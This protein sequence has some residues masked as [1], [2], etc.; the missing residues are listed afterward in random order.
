MGSMASGAKHV[1]VSAAHK[2]IVNRGGPGSPPRGGKYLWRWWNGDHWRYKYADKPANFHGH[3][4][5]AQ[6][7]MARGYDIQMRSGHLTDE[8]G[9]PVHSDVTPGAYEP[10]HTLPHSI[11]LHPDLAKHMLNEDKSLKSISEGIK[12][13]EDAEDEH[14]VEALKDIL[15]NRKRYA[16]RHHEDHFD[17]PADAKRAA[18]IHKEAQE[19]LKNQDMDKVQELRKEFDK[20]AHVRL[21]DQHKDTPFANDMYAASMKLHEMSDPAS[22]YWVEDAFDGK[23]GKMLF[24]HTDDPNKLNARHF[25]DHEIEEFNKIAQEYKKLDIDDLQRFI[26]EYE[27]L[28]DTKTVALLRKELEE[29]K[30][31]PYTFGS[32]G[33]FATFSQNLVQLSPNHKPVNR[34]F[35]SGLN[36]EAHYYI[37]DNGNKQLVKHGPITLASQKEEDSYN[38]AVQK[39]KEAG[40]DPEKRRQALAALTEKATPRVWSYLKQQGDITDKERELKQA[41]AKEP[42]KLSKPSYSMDLN[43]YA[44]YHTAHHDDR[45]SE[46]LNL[47]NIDPNFLPR[48]KAT[49]HHDD[50]GKPIAAIIHKPW[51]KE[52]KAGVDY[53]ETPEGKIEE[54]PRTVIRKYKVESLDRNPQ[55]SREVAPPHKKFD[56][57]AELQQ[58]HSSRDF[59]SPYEAEKAIG[60]LKYQRMGEEVNKTGTPDSQNGYKWFHPFKHLSEIDYHVEPK[61]KLAAHGRQYE[62]HYHP[63][64]DPNKPGRPAKSIGARKPENLRLAKMDENGRL[65][66]KNG[67]VQTYAAHPDHESIVYKLDTGKIPYTYHP[68]RNVPENERFD[69]EGNPKKDIPGWDWLKQKPVHQLVP[70]LT[71]AD[72]HELYEHPAVKDAAQVGAYYLNK[73]FPLKYQ[74]KETKK[75][76]ALADV[77]ELLPA[78]L[79]ITYAP[80]ESGTITRG[81]T[82]TLGNL[83]Q[84]MTH[85]FAH[86]ERASGFLYEFVDFEDKRGKPAMKQFWQLAKDDPATFLSILASA[87]FDQNRPDKDGKQREFGD[88]ARENYVESMVPDKVNKAAFT[89]FQNKYYELLQRHD[90]LKETDPSSSK[91]A[92]VNK[93]LNRI[94]SKVPKDDTKAIAEIN[95]A[96]LYHLAVKSRDYSKQDLEENPVIEIAP[97]LYKNERKQTKVHFHDDAKLEKIKDPERKK[98]KLAIYNTVKT[99][100]PHAISRLKNTLTEADKEVGRIDREGL[101]LVGKALVDQYTYR[102]YNDPLRIEIYGKPYSNDELAI[103]YHLHPMMSAARDRGI[104]LDDYIPTFVLLRQAMPEATMDKVKEVAMTL[105]KTAE[106]ALRDEKLM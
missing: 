23:N 15:T 105:F 83:A 1:D 10:R 84:Y 93:E 12:S 27:K 55:I 8:N 2:N 65:I 16:L 37:D 36:E 39:L 71:A 25:S 38:N 45:H 95:E 35:H 43:Q 11:D 70:K 3:G 73:Y 64:D 80:G 59:H 28:G 62:I 79:T 22:T 34:L 61:K 6:Q 29:V 32:P 41:Y 63:G 101:D 92:D 33:F 89:P 48:S 21:K 99:V 77:I 85:A 102:S 14:V 51:A 24:Q 98:T 50:Q 52:E 58:K 30:K 31:D 72:L 42:G 88:A 94:L 19:A 17:N 20:L 44:D 7:A 96:N 13:A 47:A 5:E 68:P 76:D 4:Q 103:R 66:I 60:W 74:D 46:K 9:N 56:V 104:P 97:M 49:I 106:D 81:F 75:T 86:P 53:R 18:E 100:I 26:K 67:Q 87:K 82:P 40:D 57:V 54:V 69:A 90:Q 78:A 91:L